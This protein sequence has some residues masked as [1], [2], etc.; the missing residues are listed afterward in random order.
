MGT[1][2]W[3]VN[4]GPC[5]PSWTGSLIHRDADANPQEQNGLARSLHRLRLA[6]SLRFSPLNHRPKP[7]YAYHFTG[8]G[9]AKRHGDSIGDRRAT[10]A[11]SAGSSPASAATGAPGFV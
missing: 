3:A 7:V 5:R 10:L 4:A 6:T 11:R 1:L 2:G 8:R 9:P